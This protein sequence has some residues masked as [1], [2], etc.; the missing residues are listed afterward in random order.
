M[1]T[2]WEEV[3]SWYDKVVGESGHYFHE[4]IILPR[5]LKL[6]SF[7]EKK[8][9]RLLDLGC[10]TGVLARHLPSW[11]DYVG[12]DASKSMIDRAKRNR[13]GVYVVSDAAAPSLPIQ[14]LFSH[15][16]LILSLQ[17]MEFPEK[18]FANAAK[19]LAPSGQ[20]YM[21]LNHP[22]FRIPRQTS[23]GIDGEKKIQYR[24]I[25]RY[26]TPLEIPVSI[27][28]EETFSYHNPISTYINHLG[29]LGLG[30]V[31]A[32]EWTSDK[33]STGKAARMEN[34]ARTE[35]P[36]FLLLVAKKFTTATSE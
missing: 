25:D 2:S 36:L 15:I 13:K 3:S 30:V 27:A 19:H 23:W 7:D 8:E 31:K 12:V 5:L 1:K 9:A 26:L 29:N 21:V 11:V 32:E 17:N 14:G 34:R 33:E 20:L 24:R 18:V 10:G 22:C 16:T 4:H 6:F 35:F 28:S